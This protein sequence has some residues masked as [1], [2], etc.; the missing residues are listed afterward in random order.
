MQMVYRIALAIELAALAVVLVIGAAALC[1]EMA[2]EERE[3]THDR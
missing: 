1:A 3:E 2:R